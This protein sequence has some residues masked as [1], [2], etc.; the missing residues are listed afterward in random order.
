[1]SHQFRY[2]YFA[3]LLLEQ[4]TSD[5]QI[6][7]KCEDT[8]IIYRCKMPKDVGQGVHFKHQQR[9]PKSRG[10]GWRSN[11][12]TT[13][14]FQL[15]LTN[16]RNSVYFLL[17]RLLNLFAKFHILK[18]IIFPWI[19]FFVKIMTREELILW[20]KDLLFSFRIINLNCKTVKC[21]GM[22][23]GLVV[24]VVSTYWVIIGVPKIIALGIYL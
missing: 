5:H 15:K 2:P 6:L 21:A 18:E 24:D 12:I 7:L 22:G 19:R 8:A 11:F 17:W 3:L 14:S 13:C 9:V 10:R 23:V 16:N 4:T 1:M 20:K